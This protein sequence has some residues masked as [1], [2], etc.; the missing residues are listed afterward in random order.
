MKDLREVPSQ[1]QPVVTPS[2]GRDAHLATEAGAEVRCT[3]AHRPE[4][5]ALPAK[6][7]G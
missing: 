6:N 3:T 7:L 2:L 4:S 5:Q 1:L